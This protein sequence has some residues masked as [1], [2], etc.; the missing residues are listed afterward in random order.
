[1]KFKIGDRVRVV[2]IDNNTYYGNATYRA[3]DIG[4]IIEYD[5]FIGDYHIEFDRL[6]QHRQKC[7]WWAKEDW[8]EPIRRPIMEFE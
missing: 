1:M 7:D 2:R 4:T 3:Y 8:L 5:E 6:K